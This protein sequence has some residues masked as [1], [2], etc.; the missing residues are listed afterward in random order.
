MKKLLLAALVVL[1]AVS[2][3]AQVQFGV[4]AG[5]NFADLKFSNWGSSTP[6][7]KSLVSF[8]A[9]AI[10]D[11]T[12]AESLAI[13]P[14][15]L[16]S[17]KGTKEDGGDGKITLNYIEIPVNVMYKLNAGSVKVLLMAGPSFGYA[18][19]GKDSGGGSSSD[20]TFG[21][22]PGTFKRFD[23]GFGF[24]AGVQFSSIQVTANYNLGLANI[25]NN[26]GSDAKLK[27]TVLGLSLAYLFGGK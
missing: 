17:Q 23:C 6:A 22:D 3:N 10:A 19:S 20:I 8:H 9:G 15:L 27:T 4:K 21:S 11:I 1:G 25:I 5:L 2:V 14:G 18:L 12:I 16:F 13:Q 7:T 24:G 26:G